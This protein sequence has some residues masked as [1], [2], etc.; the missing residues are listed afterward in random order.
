MEHEGPAVCSIQSKKRKVPSS[1][2]GKGTYGVV[3]AHG[4]DEIIKK[5]HPPCDLS[6]DQV[7]ETAVLAA[8]KHHP[9][10]VTLVHLKKRR[11]SLR[12]A[13]CIK[14]EE[15]NLYQFVNR[16]RSGGN[17]LP[18]IA[19]LP[20]FECILKGLAA[21]HDLGFIHGDLKMDNVMVSEYTAKLCD[22]GLARTSAFPGANSMFALMY[23]APE[24]LIDPL[25]LK[26]EPDYNKPLINTAVDLFAFGV[27]IT[28]VCGRPVFQDCESDA[29][30]IR[31][32]LAILD[33]GKTRREWRD[34]AAVY[35]TLKD[36]LKDESF[37]HL[38]NGEHLVDFTDILHRGNPEPY[39]P[40]MLETIYAC[41]QVDPKSRPH[42]ARAV[43]EMLEVE[44]EPLRASLTRT[45]LPPLSPD[46]IEL[47]NRMLLHAM[48]Q[49]IK[50]FR[51][52]PDVDKKHVVLS[53]RA[54]RLYARLVSECPH[55]DDYWRIAIGAYMFGAHLT[56]SEDRCLFT[57][58]I[59]K[60]FSETTPF[61]ITERLVLRY[62]EKVFVATHLHL[63]GGVWPQDVFEWV[64]RELAT[65]GIDERE[66]SER[67]ASAP[68][69]RIAAIKFLHAWKTFDKRE[70][71]LHV[72]GVG[73]G[74]GSFGLCA[75]LR[76]CLE[77]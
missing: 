59:A 66:E 33:H 58:E 41:L 37:G 55:Q 7:R 10:I 76:P 27:M 72:G 16:S 13:L 43:A 45:P 12:Y 39:P 4:N 38:L 36:E 61:K 62:L 18:P 56:V 71:S 67:H 69:E 54:L 42:S 19:W 35:T 22:L 65:D 50:L 24:L 30:Q 73:L 49:L 34:K 47:R 68:N 28:S 14:R 74:S 2:L 52:T 6:E 9:N 51:N 17:L 77:L 32:V 60:L 8:L 3:H 29:K 53:F 21:I 63:V 48:W 25:F 44:P 1:K 31:C 70:D 15:E 11:T 5:P 75:P 23:R 26:T 64:L 20:V 46:C 57:D 40:S